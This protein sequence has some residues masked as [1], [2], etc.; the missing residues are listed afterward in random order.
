MEGT[1]NRQTGKLL[2]LL[3]DVASSRKPP[4]SGPTPG[5]LGS[6]FLASPLSFLHSSPYLTELCL[7]THLLPHSVMS[8]L[9]MDY[10]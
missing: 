3:Q 10:S 5:V 4:L 9:L 8:I 2:F 7:S 1:E 6:L